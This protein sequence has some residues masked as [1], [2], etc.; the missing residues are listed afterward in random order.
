M[1]RTRLGFQRYGVLINQVLQWI[2]FAYQAVAVIVFLLALF[3]ANRWI[4]QPFLGAF[5][6]HTMVFN[7]TGPGEAD[8]AWFLYEQVKVGD[9]LSPLAE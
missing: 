8:P 3:F 9:Q 2:V 4:Q 6:E 5:Y 1:Q 7:G